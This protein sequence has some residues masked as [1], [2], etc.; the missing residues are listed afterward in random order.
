MV[1]IFQKKIE[2]GINENVAI[3]EKENEKKWQN[4][5]VSN[6]FHYIKKFS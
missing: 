2:H 5:V 6:L 1:M 3:L 4:F